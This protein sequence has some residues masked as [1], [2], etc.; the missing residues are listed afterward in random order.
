MPTG[1][2]LGVFRPGR[3]VILCSRH[4]FLSGGGSGPGGGRFDPFGGGGSGPGGGRFDPF[5]G[6]GS[7]LRR[8]RFSQLPGTSRERSG[9]GLGCPWTRTGGGR[10]GGRGGTGSGGSVRGLRGGSGPFRCGRG[11]GGLRPGSGGSGARV[12]AVPVVGITDRY[13]D[14]VLISSGRRHLARPARQL[15]TAKAIRIGGRRRRGR[16]SSGRR[17][18]ASRSGGGRVF[19]SCALNFAGILQA[20]DV[21]GAERGILNDTQ[22]IAGTRGQVRIHPPQALIQQRPMQVVLKKRRRPIRGSRE[23]GIDQPL[24][25]PLLPEVLHAPT[26]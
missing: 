7:G 25:R 21:H 8:G 22:L 4:V 19:R 6:G 24:L 12:V 2:G 9:H 16:R 23:R 14:A 11:S 17:I 20:R 3:S 26:L 5:G 18:G 10:G 15:G 13:R 1:Q